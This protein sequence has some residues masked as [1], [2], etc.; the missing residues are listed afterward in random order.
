MELNGQKRE[1]LGKKVK[2][3]RYEGD[4]PCVIFGKGIDS[5]PI[6]VN[7]NDFV[8]VFKEA[9]E[10]SVIDLNVNGDK[11][12]VLVKEMQ[13]HH[14]TSKPIH[15]GFYKV[16]MT[17]KL[18][19]NIPVEIINEEQNELVT[20]GEALVLTLLQEIE[21]EALPSDLPESFVLDASK[22]IDMDSTITVADLGYD[23]EKVEIVGA[24]EDEVVAKLDYAQ[25]L[26]EEEEEVDE[27]E[28]M[29]DIEAT[30]EKE[31]GEDEPNAEEEKEQENSSSN[32][33]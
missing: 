28:L 4:I 17:Q 15:V 32:D 20:S 27:A 1:I 23:R 7:Y 21:V 2:D 18:T 19:A 8:K 10:T 31:D 30:G 11:Y 5:V 25:M 9:G 6:T 33:E 22:L 16:D 12:P 13:F 14:I 29:A 3:I 24:E 26:E